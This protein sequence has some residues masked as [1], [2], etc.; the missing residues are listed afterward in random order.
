MRARIAPT[1]A[2]LFFATACAWAVAEPWHGDAIRYAIIFMALSNAAILSAY[3]GLT[4]NAG[5]PPRGTHAAKTRR[6]N[7]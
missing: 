6:R 5:D 1:L 3:F 7:P 2:F 4:D